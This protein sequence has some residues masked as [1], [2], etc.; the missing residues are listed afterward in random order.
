MFHVTLAYKDPR[1]RPPP[2]TMK[3]SHTE[4]ERRH[5]GPL[6]CPDFLPQEPLAL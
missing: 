5:T 2:P 4:R 3:E 1:P 6:L